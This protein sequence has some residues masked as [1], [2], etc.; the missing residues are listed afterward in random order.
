MPRKIVARG[1]S[2]KNKDLEFAQALAEERGR[3]LDQTVKLLTDQ[4]DRTPL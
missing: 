1:K 3:L 2:N 4:R